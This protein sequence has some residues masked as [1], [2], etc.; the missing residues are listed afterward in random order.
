[1]TN[2]YL[3]L[4]H[5]SHSVAIFTA[6][7]FSAKLSSSVLRIGGVVGATL[8]VI[9][10]LLA[11]PSWLPVMILVWILCGQVLAVRGGP[12]WIPLATCCVVL[13]I[14]RPGWPL[15]LTLLTTTMLSVAVWRIWFVRSGAGEK[16]AV[17][18]RP[19]TAGRIREWAVAVVLGAAWT[20]FAIDWSGVARRP[21]TTLDPIRPVVCLGDSL[22]SFGYPQVLADQLSVPV[23]DLGVAGI[24]SQQGVA[25]IDEILAAK[26]QAVV[27]ELG[28]HDFMKGKSR[29]ETATNLVRLIEASRSVGA[30][31]ILMEIPR[32]FITDGY[33]GLERQLAQEYQVELIADTPIRH[34]VLWSPF[35][36]PGMWF[37]SS[38]HLSN[39]GLHP[40]DQGNQE[41]AEQV[42]LALQR[43]YGPEVLRNGN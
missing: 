8:A 34:L 10:S 20:W 28:G 30:V 21:T 1:L 38:M 4:F 15:S 12:G 32:G 3:T 24:T 2:K 43:V 9:V 41:L 5:G 31:V 25:K 27:I 16:T 13:L 26:P 33:S 39:D 11:F 37:P 14:K 42:A 7:I 36:P 22:T 19:V 17:D 40:N 18:E 6:M 35:A 29:R 23:V